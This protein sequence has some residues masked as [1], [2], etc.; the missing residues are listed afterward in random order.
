MIWSINGVR[1]EIEPPAECGGNGSDF[2]IQSN[3]T[4]SVLHLKSYENISQIL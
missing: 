1:P 3:N 2:G 4:L